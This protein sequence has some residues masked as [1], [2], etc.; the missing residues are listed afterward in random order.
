MIATSEDLLA[1]QAD[2]LGDSPLASTVGSAPAREELPA[3]IRAR[4]AEHPVHGVLT[5]SDHVVEVTAAVAADFGLPDQ[6]RHTTAN[7]RDKAV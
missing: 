6:P 2:R 3:A 5:F 1:G 7:F 4:A